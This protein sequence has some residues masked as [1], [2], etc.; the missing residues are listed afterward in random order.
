MSELLR[1]S[2]PCLPACPPAYPYLSLP[3]SPRTH[4]VPS[5]LEEA[6]AADER[7]GRATQ[8]F[9]SPPASFGCYHLFSA[10]P[11]HEEGRP[12]HAR[13]VKGSERT[14]GP[15]NTHDAQLPSLQSNGNLYPPKSHPCPLIS[16]RSLPRTHRRR[17]RA[18]SL[19]P[20]LPPSL[21]PT[22]AAGDCVHG[23]CSVHV[24]LADGRLAGRPAQSHT[25]AAAAAVHR[26]T[27]C[28]AAAA[29]T[30]CGCSWMDR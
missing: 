30:P 2:F 9:P 26:C 8:S 20:S 15:Q 29:C 17:E 6:V 10:D 27:P 25:H 3:C 13:A 24:W 5:T 16:L 7:G 1:S 19:Q 22:F 11:T 18:T 28:A 21:A 12:R 14:G 23:G 4:A